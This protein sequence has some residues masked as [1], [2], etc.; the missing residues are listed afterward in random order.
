[1]LFEIKRE[2]ETKLIINPS[3]STIFPSFNLRFLSEY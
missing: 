3:T 1:M 2:K